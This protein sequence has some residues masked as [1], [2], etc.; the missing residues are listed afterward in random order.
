MKFSTAFVAAFTG[1]VAAGP[2][3]IG[4]QASIAKRQ[5]DARLQSELQK[6]GE[7]ID[8][9]KKV[10]DRITHDNGAGFQH[11]IDA[12]QEVHDAV[13]KASKEAPDQLPG[14]INKLDPIIER[15]SKIKESLNKQ[16]TGRIDTLTG[17]KKQL[18]EAAK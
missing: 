10:K 12:L 17:I 2:L 5:D 18:E 4:H 1:L 9:A 13:S 14:E 16:F 15:I 11:N 7:E 8:K 3:A 6:L